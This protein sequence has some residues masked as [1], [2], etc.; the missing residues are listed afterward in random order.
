MSAIAQELTGVD[1]NHGLGIY[2]GRFSNPAVHGV[3]IIELG[4]IQA[5]GFYC[6]YQATVLEHWVLDPARHPDHRT[7]VTI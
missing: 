3:H 1:L 4:D 2:N 7:S 5:P 6:L